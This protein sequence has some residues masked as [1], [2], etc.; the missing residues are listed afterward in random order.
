MDDGTRRKLEGAGRQL[1]TEVARK[2]FRVWMDALARRP[3]T[4]WKLVRRFRRARDG[5]E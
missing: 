5:K 3:W 1:A 2:G 4:K